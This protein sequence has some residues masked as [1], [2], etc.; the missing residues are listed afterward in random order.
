MESKSILTNLESTF[1]Q[2]IKKLVKYE[3]RSTIW[4]SDKSDS[5]KWLS[6]YLNI[7]LTTTFD[8]IKKIVISQAHGLLSKP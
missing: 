8:L 6:C 3:Y 1:Q 7:G 2:F 4:R 5:I